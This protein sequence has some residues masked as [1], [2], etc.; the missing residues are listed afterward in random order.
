[1]VATALTA[2]ALVPAAALAR[3]DINAR[4]T[5]PVAAV[6]ASD[7]GTPRPAPVVVVAPSSASGFD[8]GDAT[9]G[10]GSVL[11]LGLLIAGGGLLWSHRH[12]QAGPSGPVAAG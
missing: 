6:V 5:V 7:V 4:G 1:M 8:W 9:I 10:A 12:H 11:A 3:P 2:G